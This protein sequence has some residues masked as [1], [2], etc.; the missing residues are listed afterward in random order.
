MYRYIPPGT[1]I[2]IPAYALHRCA[3]Y[4]SPNPET[5][6]PERWLKQSP[7]SLTMSGDTDSHAI[8][9]HSEHVTSFVTNGSA[10]IPFSFGPANCVGKNLAMVEMRIVVA[11]LV[12]RFDLHI[13][14][15][16]NPMDWHK[17]QE[18]FFALKNGR[19]PVVLKP[20]S[21]TIE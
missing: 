3:S 11:T 1:A 4:F 8:D 9:G 6:W 15:E 13:S 2:N 21:V 5:F 16:Y 19:L 18:D 20:R 14:H 7:E 10:F 17:D 12:T